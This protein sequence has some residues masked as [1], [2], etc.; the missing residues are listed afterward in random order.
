MHILN[1]FKIAHY[2]VPAYLVGIANLFSHE[3]RFYNRMCL[4]VLLMIRWS[5]KH[6]L[7]L[8]ASSGIFCGIIITLRYREWGKN[9][10][11][12]N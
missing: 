7:C 4:S 10:S 5:V 12:T 3:L 8:R 2:L 6:H 9:L 11:S 1:A